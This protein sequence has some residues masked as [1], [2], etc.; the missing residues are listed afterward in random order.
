VFNRKYKEELSIVQ[1]TGIIMVVFSSL[2]TF[3]PFSYAMW[4]LF[5]NLM[6]DWKFII[7]IVIGIYFFVTFIGVIEIGNIFFK[8]VD[9]WGKEVD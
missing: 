3:L 2:L 8:K 6:G 4:S 7:G 5:S 1:K 9:Q